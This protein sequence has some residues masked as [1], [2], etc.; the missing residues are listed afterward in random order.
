MDLNKVN[1]A[2]SAAVESAGCEIVDIEYDKKY[3]EMNLTVYVYKKG[4]TL[5]DCEK[6]H[7]AIDPILDELDPTC[8]KPYNL[9]VSS[10]GLDRPFKTQRDFERNYDTEVELKLF[11]PQKGKKLF[12]G[13]L[14]NRGENVTVIVCGQEEFT[15][16]NSKIAFVRPLVKFE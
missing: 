14:K 10:P 5:D 3:G 12:E 11:A 4:L 13:V 1:N 8:G 9:N 16:E 2:I 15:F 6:V 7:Y